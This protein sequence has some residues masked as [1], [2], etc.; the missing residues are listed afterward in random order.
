MFIQTHFM[1]STVSVPMLRE[2]SHLTSSQKIISKPWLNSF[3]LLLSCHFLPMVA[4]RHEKWKLSQFRFSTAIVEVWSL[5]KV[6]ENRVV[7]RWVLTISN[8]HHCSHSAYMSSLSLV[9]V[10]QNPPPW[11]PKMTPLKSH[12]Q[13]NFMR[14]RK[15]LVQPSLNTIRAKFIAFPTIQCCVGKIPVRKA[16]ILLQRQIWITGQ[17]WLWVALTICCMVH[18]N[19]SNKGQGTSKILCDK[20][21]FWASHVFKWSSFLKWP[22]GRSW[23]QHTTNAWTI[24]AADADAIWLLSFPLS[25]PTTS[26]SMAL[27][28]ATAVHTKPWCL[29]PMNPAGLPAQP[30]PNKKVD[31]PSIA[32]WLEYCDKHP[33]HSGDNLSKHIFSFNKEG[34]RRINQLTSNRVSVE[35]LASW[36][37]IGMGIADLVIWYADEDMALVNAGQFTMTLPTNDSDLDGHHENEF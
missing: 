13:M 14:R 26:E 29:P 18:A 37:K 25:A 34:Y 7:E 27:S 36:V 35:K 1:L 31:C 23:P 6:A 33:I 30:L 17:H 3:G 5:G 4:D 24:P 19:S 8:I 11:G 12:R 22:Y 20:E 10:V 21:A 9:P 32:P 28:Y 2:L 15:R 16:A